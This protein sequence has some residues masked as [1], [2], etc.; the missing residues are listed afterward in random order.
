MSKWMNA[1]EAPRDGSWFIGFSNGDEVKMRWAEQRKCMLGGI[2]GGNGYLGEG[3]ECDADGGL[4]C[5]PPEKWR[6][7]EEGET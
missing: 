2:G 1:D 5:D 4:I 7:L 6:E 3:W